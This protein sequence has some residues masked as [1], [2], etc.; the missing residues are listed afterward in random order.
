VRDDDAGD[1]VVVDAYTTPRSG[2]RLK[3]APGQK[4][5]RI[6]HSSSSVPAMVPSTMPAMAPPESVLGQLSEEVVDCREKRA[7]GWHVLVI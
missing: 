4:H 2:S 7:G 5:D 1:V 3:G 6:S